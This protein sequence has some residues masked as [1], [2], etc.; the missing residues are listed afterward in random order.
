MFHSIGTPG[1]LWF[2]ISTLSSIIHLYCTIAL[3]F[4][5]LVPQVRCGLKLGH[6]LPL[7]SCT[8]L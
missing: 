1:T 8:E 7:L 2:V 6:V 4:I 3:L 5:V